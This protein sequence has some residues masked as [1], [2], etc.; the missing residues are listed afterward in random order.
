[1]FCKIRSYFVLDQGDPE[2]LEESL[3]SRPEVWPH[4]R[5]IRKVD[6]EHSVYGEDNVDGGEDDAPAE[7]VQPAGDEER[8]G[9][10][11]E[12]VEDQA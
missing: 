12:A 7:R 5:T 4:V 1:M 2:R 11:E 6:P 3:I 8:P 10:G 9:D